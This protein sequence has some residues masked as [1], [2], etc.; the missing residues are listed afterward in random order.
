MVP[1]MS[2]DDSQQYFSV[3][4]RLNVMMNANMMMEALN[5]IIN[6]KRL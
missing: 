1:A 6:L 5:D 2:I 4:F 3:L